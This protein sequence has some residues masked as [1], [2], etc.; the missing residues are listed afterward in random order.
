MFLIECSENDSNEDVHF[1]SI[2]QIAS[3][4]E[5]FINKI[6]LLTKIPDF[7]VN[8]SSLQF[9]E[10]LIYYQLDMFLRVK[11]DREAIN[12]ENTKTRDIELLK[13]SFILEEASIKEQVFLLSDLAFTVLKTEQLATKPSSAVIKT[14]IAYLIR[15][16]IV[17]AKERESKLSAI[18]EVCLNLNIK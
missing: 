12:I 13:N 9:I 1:Y 11:G 5:A 17:Y 8:V 15:C 6:G 3:F 14:Q 4:I 18:I 7:S 16:A 10:A 2:S